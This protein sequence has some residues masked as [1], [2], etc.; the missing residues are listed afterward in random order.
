MDFLTNVEGMGRVS[1]CVGGLAVP[2]QDRVVVNL[3][4]LEAYGGWDCRSAS[5]IV[6][7]VCSVG[8]L[9]RLTGRVHVLAGFLGGGFL[10]HHAAPF[11]DGGR[12]SLAS[13][14][15]RVVEIGG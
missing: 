8:R 4:C 2:R 13:F 3:A 5:L 15:D 6:V 11:N 12:M 14:S 1:V 9:S 10:S 7:A